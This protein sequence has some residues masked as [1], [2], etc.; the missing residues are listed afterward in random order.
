[1]KFSPERARD[2][3]GKVGGPSGGR[4]EKKGKTIKQSGL[5]KKRGEIVKGGKEVLNLSPPSKEV[6]W[7]WEEGRKTVPVQGTDSP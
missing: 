4:R 6:N 7:G 3:G 1:M 5:I 2:K